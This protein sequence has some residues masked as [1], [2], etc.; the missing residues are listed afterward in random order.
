MYNRLPV[1]PEADFKQQLE[2]RIEKFARQRD[3][4]REQVVELTHAL[5]AIEKRLETATEMYRLEFGVDPTVVHEQQPRAA[6]PK[7]T[8]ESWNEAI[9]GVLTE[10]ESP[11]HITE[12]WRRVQGR[13]FT[14]SA[15]DPLRA[16]AAVLVRHPNAVRRGPNTYALAGTDGATSGQQPLVNPDDDIAPTQT[17]AA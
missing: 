11:L 9:E 6:R 17:E 4:L 16:I 7:K 1:E 15:K 12:I 10:A 14:T 8:G 13:G 2:S 5:G 3:E